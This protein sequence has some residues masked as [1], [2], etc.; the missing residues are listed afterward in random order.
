MVT[1]GLVWAFADTPAH[2]AWVLGYLLPIEGAVRF[3]LS[4]ATIAGVW[5]SA[6]EILREFSLAERFPR[7]D[8]DVPAV[9]FR[10][11][12]AFVLAIVA[13]V[14]VRSLRRETQ[15]RHGRRSP[16]RRLARPS[17]PPTAS[18]RRVKR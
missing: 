10:C 14:F 9:A 11:G 7:H 16:R 5:F 8:V 4:G 2:P 1:I 6:S 13:G 18:A 15:R 17:S 3:G 12:M